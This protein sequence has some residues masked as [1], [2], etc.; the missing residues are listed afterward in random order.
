MD[1]RFGTGMLEVTVI[2][3]N[4]SDGMLTFHRN[5]IEPKTRLIVGV[6]LSIFS[7]WKNKNYNY[8]SWAAL[9]L[10]PEEG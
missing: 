10:F 8:S 7:Q 5:T 9:E 2:C 1:M 3:F 6:N 4:L